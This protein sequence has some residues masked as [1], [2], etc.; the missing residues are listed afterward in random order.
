[1]RVSDDWIA[2]EPANCAAYPCEHSRLMESALRE[3]LAARR[4]V[5]AARL[6]APHLVALF[7]QHVT[8]RP[9]DEALA[10]YDKETA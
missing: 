1:M 4:V 3:L 9:L 2:G 7:A 6:A 10:A 5:E 8:K